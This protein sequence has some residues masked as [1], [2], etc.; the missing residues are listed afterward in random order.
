MNDYLPVPTLVAGWEDARRRTFLA[1]N[2]HEDS[3][4]PQDYWTEL[5]LGAEIARE[6]TAGRWVVVSYLLRSGAVESWAQVGRA[7]DMTETEARDGFLGWIAGQR[8]LNTR[9]GTLGLNP[10]DAE[11]LYR[12][13]EAVT[14]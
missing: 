4:H 10:A 1:C 6:V 11:E 12:L 9:T 5:R 13:A 2:A 3:A 7:V 8:D 14:Y